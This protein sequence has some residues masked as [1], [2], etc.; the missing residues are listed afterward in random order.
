MFLYSVMHGP[1]YAQIGQDITFDLSEILLPPNIHPDDIHIAW[2]KDYKL[3]PK[4][5]SEN[6]WTLNLWDVGYPAEGEYYCL[7]GVMS[8]GEMYRTNRIQLEI[9]EELRDP[10]I[11]YET[12]RRIEVPIGGRVRF[13]PHCIVEPSWLHRKCVWLREGIQLGT[14]EQFS[15]TVE[16]ASYYGIYTLATTAFSHGGYRETYAS[17][18]IELVPPK[19]S[20]CKDIYVHD[21]NQYEHLKHLGGGRNGAYMWIG[22]WVHDEIIEA[23]IEGFEWH[24]DPMNERFKYKCE[25][26][27]IAEILEKY[28]DIEVQESRHGYILE[29]K[30]LIW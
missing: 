5:D 16:D 19:T 6:P 18:D 4:L 20:E 8:T 10:I 21:L 24:K 12:R 14:D 29:R 9:G 7:L 11:R 17:I 13:A 2:Y 27:K 25:L 1:H 30:D 3:I 26:A 15:L 22:W 28:P 23:L